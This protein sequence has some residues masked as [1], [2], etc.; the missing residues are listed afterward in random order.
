MFW[1]L[2]SV[3]IGFI[4]NFLVLLATTASILFKLPLNSFC[5][6]RQSSQINYLHITAQRPSSITIKYNSL[7]VAQWSPS[8]LS[9]C[10]GIVIVGRTFVELLLW[11]YRT[12]RRALKLYTRE[13]REAQNW[14][15]GDFAI[16]IKF[17]QTLLYSV[18]G[19]IECKSVSFV[20][21]SS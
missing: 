7:D 10:S 8:S 3:V 6:F 2:F 16:S 18:S 19:R 5:Y 17:R 21:E 11:H 20:S 14:D 15:V 9:I 13:D 12:Q 4:L 1:K